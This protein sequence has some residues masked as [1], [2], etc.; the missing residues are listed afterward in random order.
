MEHLEFVSVPV[1]VAAVVGCLELLKKLTKYNEKV[2]K[3]LPLIAAGL[4][5]ALGLIAFFAYP[6]IIPADN[7][8]L[9]LL[10][11]GSSG[12]AATGT[13]QV[14]KQLLKKPEQILNL[15]KNSSEAKNE[16]GGDEQE[17]DKG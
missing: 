14:F 8:F 13:H 16:E 17:G 6:L 4:G 2:L 11:G 12:L 7:A 10:I 5:M 3:T 1:I 9:A 15:F